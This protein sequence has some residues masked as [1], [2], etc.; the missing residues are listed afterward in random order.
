MFSF[1]KK[2]SDAEKF[3]APTVESLAN[4]KGGICH[5][6]GK[7]H[8]KLAQHRQVRRH[9]RECEAIQVWLD[10]NEFQ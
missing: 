6:L 7:R 5:K 3:N 9:E 2:P 4:N 1:F 8:V 10:P